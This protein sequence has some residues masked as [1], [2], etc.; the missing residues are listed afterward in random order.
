M[1]RGIGA[2][3]AL[4]VLLGIVLAVLIVPTMR[5]KA[6]LNK[7][8]A[9]L[10]PGVVL[11]YHD[12]HYA[13]LARRVTLRDV[14]LK[15]SSPALDIHAD[16]LEIDG[17][18]AA[19]EQTAAEAQSAPDLQNTTSTPLAGRIVATGLHTASGPVDV[20]VDREELDKPSLDLYQVFSPLPLRAASALPGLADAAVMQRVGLY[21]VASS[22][23]R[24][25]MDNLVV[26]VRTD[27][28]DGT[29]VTFRGAAL[30]ADGIDHGNF[31]HT[32]LNG[33]EIASG[34][35]NA[36]V[37][38]IT[39]GA[40]AHR[41]FWTAVR[42]G[43]PL[44][45]ASEFFQGTDE[46]IEDVKATSN[47]QTIASLDKL[48]L[49][50]IAYKGGLPVSLDL[51]FS[52]V[53]FDPGLLP[54]P[55]I[56]DGL[57]ALGYKMVQMDGHASYRWDQTAQ[58]IRLDPAMITMDQGGTLTLTANALNADPNLAY[59]QY[60]LSGASLRYDDASLVTKW[61]AFAAAQTKR[62]PPDIQ[63]AYAKWLL[64]QK[65]AFKNDPTLAAAFDG[66]AAFIK[67][68]HSL[69]VMLAPAQPVSLFQFDKANPQSFSTRLGLKVSAVPGP[70]SSAP[71]A[72]PVPGH[73]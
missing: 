57:R 71:A 18:N 33:F 38:R 37:A 9:A 48:T 53:T 46:T 36:S 11:T 3:A 1:K 17:G 21:I 64:E 67:N 24:A 69:L 40:T 44:E 42:D 66:L 49:G 43:A 60:K 72:I 26:E 35:F 34:T 12:P 4:A 52:H 41:A 6:G 13:L 51:A 47:G 55:G 62:T 30:S 15:L 7:L 58:T 25:E 68:P 63:A 32:T 31:A 59:T 29:K 10:P 28:A 50:G 14:T 19:L 5:L 2:V 27:E 56:G 73:R 45:V 54:Y 70:G 39:G 65:P 23:D 16:S 22:A 61:L 8:A 20:H